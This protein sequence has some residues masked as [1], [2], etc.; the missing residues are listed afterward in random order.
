MNDIDQCYRTIKDTLP[1]IQGWCSE[2]KA[3]TLASIIIGLRLKVSCE[4]GVFHGRSCFPMARAH[5]CVGGKVVAIDP[6]SA[7][8][9]SNGYTGANYSYWNTTQRMQNAEQQFRNLIANYDLGPWV[10]IRKERSDDVVP[11]ECELLHVDGQH[12]QQAVRDVQRFTSKMPAGGI[13]FL[14]DINWYN[15]N[16][17]DVA[18]A[19][20]WLLLN[21]FE[22]LYKIETSAVYRK[23]KYEAKETKDEKT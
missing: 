15:D 8:E 7:K 6:W 19:V 23:M 16:N 2:N 14:D 10:D 18:D 1:G 22:E 20:K 9:A 3:F 21:G 12:T 17:F 11:F 5:C 13:V 4:I